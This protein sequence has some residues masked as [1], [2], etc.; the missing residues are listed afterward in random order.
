MGEL[1]NLRNNIDEIDQKLV[2]L[3]ARR[4]E[5]VKKI[6]ILKKELKLATLQSGRWEEVL[7]KVCEKGKTLDLSREFIEDIWNRIHQESLKIE[8]KIIDNHD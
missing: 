7:N 1:I 5:V 8:E 6:G 2:E 3:L 4:Y